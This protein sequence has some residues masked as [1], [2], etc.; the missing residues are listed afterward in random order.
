MMSDIKH[1]L[2]KAF[3]KGDF[4]KVVYEKTSAEREN[5]QNLSDELIMLHN[6]GLIDVVAGFRILQ[7]R[8]ETGV[9]FF[10]T[11][12][13]FE[14]ILPD[15]DASV[16]PVMECVLHLVNEAGQDMTAGLL[17]SPYIDFCALNSFRPEEAL[18]FILKIVFN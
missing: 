1:D 6:E 4:L 11:R 9:D 10:L 7:N 14:K 18:S 5:R 13:V 3:E 2:L 16:L 15:L 12:H 17:F 8:S